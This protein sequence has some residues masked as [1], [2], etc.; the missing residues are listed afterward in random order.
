LRRRHLASPTKPLGQRNGR[1]IAER[2][3][4]SKLAFSGQVGALVDC[5]ENR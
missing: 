4:D 5:L 2:G 1:K 3:N